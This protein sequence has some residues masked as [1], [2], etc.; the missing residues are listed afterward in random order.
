[1]LHFVGGEAPVP[2]SA[3][4]AASGAA[5]SKEDSGAGLAPSAARL[6]TPPRRGA[7]LAQDFLTPQEVDALIT[8][9]VPPVA[10]GVAPGAAQASI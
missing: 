10:P 3:S 5:E 9:A 1:M 8:A 6:A 7:K 4:A 2:A